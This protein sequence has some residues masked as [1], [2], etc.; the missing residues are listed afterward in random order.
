MAPRYPV[1]QTGSF[2]F[3]NTPGGQ[4]G[5]AQQRPLVV[6][7]YIDYT[8]PFSGK[9][10]NTLEQVFEIL[11]GKRGEIAPFPVHFIMYQLPQPWHPQSTYLHEA[12]LAVRQILGEA[13]YFEFTKRFFDKET[14]LQKEFFDDNVWNKTRA[15]IHALLENVIKGLVK[16]PEKE[17]KVIDEYR[18]LV[19]PNLEEKQQGA[20]NYGSRMTKELKAVTKF[21]RKRGV[22]V[23]PTVFVNGIEGKVFFVASLLFVMLF[24]ATEVS[25][26]WTVGQWQEFLEQ[27]GMKTK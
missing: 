16:A 14:E 23:T 27:F 26:S 19:G 18:Q 12:G 2:H 6:E 4:E 11:D 24:L 1:Q 22:H 7:Y 8:C 17:E 3:S 13:G 5:S 25:S 21:H 10:F 15:E 20:L 9:I